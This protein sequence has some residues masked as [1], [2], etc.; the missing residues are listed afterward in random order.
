M[1][2]LTTTDIPENEQFDYWTSIISGRGV[3]LS[4]EREEKA[5]FYGK[6]RAATVG[7]ITVSHICCDDN[8]TVRTARH[9]AQDTAL[10][11]LLYIPLSSDVFISSNDNNY[12]LPV[13]SLSLVNTAFPFISN[14]ASRNLLSFKIPYHALPDVVRNEPA[15]ICANTFVPESLRRLAMVLSTEL[16]NPR[17]IPKDLTAIAETF[18]LQLNSLFSANSEGEEASRDHA[19]TFRQVCRF[20]EAN[21]FNAITLPEVA[22][23]LK[24]SVPYLKR[25]LA[26]HQVTFRNLL[27]DYRLARALPQLIH[28]YSNQGIAKLA[29]ANGFK[30]QSHFS[31]CFRESFYLPPLKFK[32]SFEFV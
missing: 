32:S 7:D 14:N 26:A 5:P 24:V 21:Y 1:H 17:P 23:S 3:S 31:K 9:I 18:L 8:L 10:Y 25:V 15:L 22:A 6:V 11:F 27:R 4:L 2:I 29:V 28:P 19:Y 13:G 12:T 16:L 30:N 20:I